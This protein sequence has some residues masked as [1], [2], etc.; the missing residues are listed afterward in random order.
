MTRYVRGSGAST[1]TTDDG[2]EWERDI[3][4]KYV[5]QQG[6]A[7]DLSF[8]VR[9]ATYRSGDGVYYGSPSIDE[10]RLIVEY[11]LSIL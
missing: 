11:P 9:Q 8:R 3:D 2:K 5:L 4:V 1:R 10:L 7:K 6:P